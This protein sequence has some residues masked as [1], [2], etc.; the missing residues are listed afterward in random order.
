MADLIKNASFTK[1]TNYAECPYR[2]NLLHVEKVP[3]P[4][5]V[6]PPGKLEHPMTRGIRVHDEGEAYVIS[7]GTKELPTEYRRHADEMKTA[8]WLYG[9][10]RATCEQMWRFDRNWQPLAD[11]DWSAYWYIKLDLEFDITKN[12]AHKGVVDY[13]T[14]KS[15]FNEVKHASQVQ[16]YCVATLMRYPKTELVSGE[17]WYTDEGKVSKAITVNRRQAIPLAKAWQTKAKVMTDARIFPAKA[18]MQTCRFCDY[19]SE[20]GNAYCQFD[21]Y[22][23]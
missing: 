8:Q 2:C 19:G 10:G 13:K 23:R 18:S 6:P 22:K 4:P 17:L 21:A 12:G 5:K 14:G 20:N 15:Y 1:L 16:L 7:Q 9:K 3:Q 11:N